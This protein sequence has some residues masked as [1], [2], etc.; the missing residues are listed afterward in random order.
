MQTST[1][2]FSA[3]SILMFFLMTS[4]ASTKVTGEWKDPN[5]TSKQ[6]KN[7]LV[8]GIAKQPKNRR[9]Y[10][11][12]F[13]RQL[14][15]KG[16]MAISSHTIISHE[17]MWDRATIV[18]TI[19]NKGFD[20]VI[21]TRVVDFKARQQYYDVNMHDYYNRSYHYRVRSTTDQQKFSFESNLYDAITEQ[22]VFSVSSNTYAQE[23]INKR[24]DSYITTVLNKLVQNNLL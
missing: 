11:D 14:Q 9:L 10:E 5:L 21:I 1:R 13:V 12:E 2:L 20:G 17:N 24:L 7:I 4:C 3:L 22:L 16:V 18:Q 6:F 15:A 8:M 23:N 19:A